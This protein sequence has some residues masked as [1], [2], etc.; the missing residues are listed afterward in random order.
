MS[1]SKLAEALKCIAEDDLDTLKDIVPA[2]VPIDV[3]LKEFLYF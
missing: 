3:K 2:H 1:D